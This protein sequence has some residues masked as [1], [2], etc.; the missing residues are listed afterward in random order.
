MKRCL[1][2]VAAFNRM[3]GTPKGD[4]AKP[5][6]TVDVALRVKLIAEEFDELLNAL[7]P[8]LPNF[9]QNNVR[10][11]VD[12]WLH[13]RKVW[14]VEADDPNLPEVADALADLAFVTIGANDVWGLP[15]DAVWEEVCRANMAKAGGPK[16]PVTGKALKPPGWT[17]PD[18]EG[19]LKRE[20][21]MASRRRPHRRGD[22]VTRIWVAPLH[23]Q[24]PDSDRWLLDEQ[25]NEVQW[26]CYELSRGGVIGK[27][28]RVDVSCAP[29]ILEPWPRDIM[30]S[31]IEER[32]R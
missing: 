13:D 27:R 18:V 17:P 16:H 19:V 24:A 10:D 3:V 22:Q 2:Q 25:I 14:E 29:E 15:G 20:A 9:I 30:P 6:A 31:E 1:E 32:R 4:V 26:W 21:D 5:D 12:R 7:A 28:H 23:H 11:A 8:N